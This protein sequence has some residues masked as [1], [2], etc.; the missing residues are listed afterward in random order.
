M[1]ITYEIFEEIYELGLKHGS[2]D[3]GE[4]LKDT[5]EVAE[6]LQKFDVPIPKVR[7]EF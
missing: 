6:L 1:N 5:A 3:D 2:S 7:P 4:Y